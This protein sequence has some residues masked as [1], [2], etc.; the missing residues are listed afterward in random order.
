MKPKIVNFYGGPG[1][2]KSTSAAATFAALKLKRINCELI[3]EFVKEAAW[4]NRSKK[5][6]M[7][8]DYL[9]GKQHFRLIQVQ[10]SVD[11]IITDSPLILGCAYIGP[12][13]QLPSLKNVIKE[14]YDCYDNL[15]IFVH[16]GA[17][18]EPAGR[19]QTL[20]EAISLDSRVEQVLHEHKISCEKVQSGYGVE[21]AVINLIHQRWPEIFKGENSAITGIT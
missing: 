1:A 10:D 17:D 7:A 4:E 14:A 12:D 11:I 18:Y 3:Q 19:N 2:G 20:D 6:F 13:Y 16:R 15:D 21:N 9:F 8:Q 5:I